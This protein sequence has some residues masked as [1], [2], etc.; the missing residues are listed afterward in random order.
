VR[1][2]RLNALGIRTWADVVGQPDRVP[3]G[4]RASLVEECRRCLVALSNNDVRYFVDR[5]APQ[6][7]W[8]VLSEFLEQTSFFDIET[9]GLEYDA[10]ITVIACWHRGHVHTFVEYENLDDFLH[11]L[12]EVT[13][14]ASFNGSSFDVPRILDSFHIPKLPCPHLDLRWSCYHRGLRG[15]LKNIAR[16]TAISRPADLADADGLLAL[17]L[18]NR[19]TMQQD[20]VARDRLLRYCA[21]DVLMLIVVASQVAG[22]TPPTNAELW[23]HLPA[24]SAPR[25]PKEVRP[26]QLSDQAVFGNASPSRIRARRVRAAG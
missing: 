2:A 20:R 5:F 10:R 21:S 26:V 4:H 6:D 8:R 9:T 12:D 19:W 13:L 16:D 15:S 7:K 25:V 17:Q 23:T 14:L 24:A 18:W 1:L 22:H 11:L 3:A